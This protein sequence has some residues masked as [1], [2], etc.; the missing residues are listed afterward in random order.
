[1][2]FVQFFYYKTA[3]HTAPC[4]VVQCGYAILRAVLVRFV[5]FM[6]FSKHPYTHHID[7]DTKIHPS[8]TKN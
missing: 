8:K 6:R 2:Q 3:N 7:S 4:G 5:R 1:M